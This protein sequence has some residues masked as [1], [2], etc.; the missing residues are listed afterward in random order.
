MTTLWIPDGNKKQTEIDITIA[1]L[2][3]KMRFLE[4][5][6]ASYSDDLILIQDSI[7]TNE[8]DIRTHKTSNG[9]TN[10]KY[11]KQLRNSSDILKEEREKIQGRL[12]T[13]NKEIDEQKIK[14]QELKKQ[15]DREATAVLEFKR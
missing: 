15:R 3:K 12:G 2:E 7:K 6:K 4:R 10:I 8:I 14:I 13:L 11:F 5:M 1:Y 9:A